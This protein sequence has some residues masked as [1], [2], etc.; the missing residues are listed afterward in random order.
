MRSLAI[1]GMTLALAAC[2]GGGTVATGTPTPVAT[3]SPTPASTGTGLITGG[4]GNTA[5]NPDQTSACSF[6]GFASDNVTVI[7]YVTVA[8]S[9]S[10]A[11]CPLFT[12]LTNYQTA[13][14]LTIPKTPVCWMTSGDGGATA[15]FYTPPGGSLTAA[16]NECT[17][18]L[19]DVGT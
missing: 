5:N 10:Q 4:M 17:W 9:N 15:R 6:K 13:T 11:L 18:E 3:A 14:G 8:G 2:G 1:L 7:V 16:K 19:Q 12:S